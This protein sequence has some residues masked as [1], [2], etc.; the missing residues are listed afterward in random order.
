MHASLS[1]VDGEPASRGLPLTVLGALL[2]APTSESIR[3]RITIADLAS[4]QSPS[5][6]KYPRYF[7]EDS[8]TLQ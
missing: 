3:P 5:P 7:F 8:I 2:L 4:S 6:A 1:E